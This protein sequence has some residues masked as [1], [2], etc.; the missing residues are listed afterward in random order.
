MN[1]FITID[2]ETY[3]GDYDRDVYGHG[4]GLPFILETCR[5]HGVRATFFVETLGAT[6][7]GPAGVRRICRDVIEAGHDVQLHVHPVVARLDG[8][9]DSGDVL[10]MHDRATQERLLDA[11]RRILTDS[12]GRDVVAFRAGDFAANEDTLEAMEA[13][14]IL[15]GSN[16]DLDTKCSTRSRVNDAFPVRRDLSRRGR[17]V[18]L[19]ASA[20]RSP[21][22]FLDGMYRHM[23]VSALGGREM[24]D[25]IVRM[26]RAGYT[27]AT[28]LTHPGEYF[29]ASGR[30][31]V[32]IAKNRRRLDQLLA[33]LAARTSC[34]VGVVS[35]CADAVP[36]PEESPPE[37]A[38]SLPLA[39]CRVWEQAFD[40]VRRKVAR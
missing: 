23:Q 30:D 40:R 27:C 2:V 16:R 14:G 3:T 31:L 36:V 26:E 19:P 20:P 6:R 17:L 4:L 8:V 11:G 32:P 34:K 24:I 10:W 22:P 21:L 1:V 38:L 39:M 28:I 12:T 33:F 7:W 5:R 18:D 37:I 25:A 35:D 15:V 29:R 13:L 9:H